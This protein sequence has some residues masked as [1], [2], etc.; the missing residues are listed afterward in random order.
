MDSPHVARR[1]HNKTGKS[2]AFSLVRCFRG[3]AIAYCRLVLC[4]AV[5]TRRQRFGPHF[6]FGRAPKAWAV[7]ISATIAAQ[8]TGRLCRKLFAVGKS[9]LRLS[10]DL[11]PL[12]YKTHVL[13]YCQ[14]SQPND[15]CGRSALFGV[16][17]RC[18]RRSHQAT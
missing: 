3:G 10:T 7:K 16:H 14:S 18:H 17:A 9:V 1:P 2:S 11:T 8:R 13:G 4:F 15:L 5:E 12:S 6:I